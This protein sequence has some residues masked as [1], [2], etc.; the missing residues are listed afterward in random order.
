M[1][2]STKPQGNLSE[3]FNDSYSEEAY[4]PWKDLNP[5]KVTEIFQWFFSWKEHGKG[6]CDC[7][8]LKR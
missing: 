7:I 8:I 3:G 4:K 5:A 6:V 2:Q 1:A